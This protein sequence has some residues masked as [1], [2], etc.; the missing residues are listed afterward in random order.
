MD[1]VRAKGFKPADDNEADALSLLDLILTQK[2]V[3]NA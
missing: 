2:G 3:S 1:A